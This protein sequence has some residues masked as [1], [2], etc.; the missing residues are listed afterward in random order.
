MHQCLDFEQTLNQLR[1]CS[2]SPLLDIFIDHTG[3]TAVKVVRTM[4]QSQRALEL[5]KYAAS[6]LLLSSILY[7]QQYKGLTFPVLILGSLLH[8]IVAQIQLLMITLINPSS[9]MGLWMLMPSLFCG[10]S[11]ASEQWSRSST[12]PHSTLLLELFA[13]TIAKRRLLS[14]MSGSVVLLL[15]L[16]EAYARYLS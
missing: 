13:T 12:I 16:L 15:K 14:T 10:G 7:N 8:L 1:I 6:S 3:D 2:Y 5:R 11:M 9:M 4:T